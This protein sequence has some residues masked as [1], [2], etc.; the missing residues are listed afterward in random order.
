MRREFSRVVRII[1]DKHAV[2]ADEIGSLEPVLIP[3]SI[4]QDWPAARRTLGC[5]IFLLDRRAIKRQLG[6][7][8][9]SS[10]VFD[11]E[12]LG[13]SIWS[14][15]MG[16]LVFVEFNRACELAPLAKGF[17]HRMV[18]LECARKTSIA[19]YAPRHVIAVMPSAPESFFA[20][21]RIQR[22]SATRICVA[23]GMSERYTS[24][25]SRCVSREDFRYIATDQRQRRTNAAMTTCEEKVAAIVGELPRS[26][27]ARG[28][29][30]R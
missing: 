28:P 8:T 9:M 14:G 15:M 16:K 1:C 10:S 19:T 23:I 27:R 2:P 29:D 12:R 25:Q 4:A 22:D 20:R 21:R 6:R 17:K 5:R 24:V 7:N 13:P 3:Q 30:R 18:R 11:N 26:R